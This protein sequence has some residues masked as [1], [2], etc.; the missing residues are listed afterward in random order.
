MVFKISIAVE[1]FAIGKYIVCKVLHDFCVDVMSSP[2]N[3][4]LAERR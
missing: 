2:T 4:F 1:L 3:K